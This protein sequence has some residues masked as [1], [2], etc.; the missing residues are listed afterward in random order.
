ML[1]MEQEDEGIEMKIAATSDTHGRHRDVT[2]PECDVLVVAGDITCNGEIE[3]VLDFC[4]WV[5]AQ[6]CESTIVVA[7]NHDWCFYA[8]NEGRRLLEERGIIYLE[9]EGVTI[10]GVRFWGSPWQ[11]E[12][13]NWAFNMPRGERLRKRWLAVPEDTDV[14]ITHGPPYGILDKVNC[15]NPLGCFD[16]LEEVVERI[17]P[18]RHIFGHIHDGYGTIDKKRTRYMNVSACDENY[19]TIN[20]PQETEL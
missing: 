8:S 7:G 3:Q 1:E 2:I 9:D 12:F 11:P 16:L 20:A 5:D 4:D 19:D 10:D 15:G 6:P 18:R 13:H 14:L 17:K